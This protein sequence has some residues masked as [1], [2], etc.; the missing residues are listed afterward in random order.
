SDI[1]TARPASQSLWQEGKATIKIAHG[2]AIHLSGRRPRSPDLLRSKWK[3]ISEPPAI[4]ASSVLPRVNETEYSVPNSR[5]KV[6]NAH[7]RMPQHTLMRM[8]HHCRAAIVY[9]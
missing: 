9:K 2:T 6:I 8:K 1:L 7:G 3:P 4:I 5:I